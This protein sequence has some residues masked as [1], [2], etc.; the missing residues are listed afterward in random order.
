MVQATSLADTSKSGSSQV[1][2][3]N[4]DVVSVQPANVTLAPLSQQTFAAIVLGASNQSVTWQVQGAGCAVSGG[5][6]TVTAN[7][8]YTAPASPPTPNSVQVVA[9]SQD[10]PA[11]SGAANV[12]ISTEANILSLHP[13]SVY[14]GGANGFTLR[15]DGSGFAASSPGPGS[16]LLI[17]G[18]ART[19]TCISATECTAAVTASDMAAVGSVSVQVRNPSGS[20]SNAVEL[21]VAAPNVSDEVISLTSGAPIATGKD[22]VAVE[23]TTAGISGP[24]NPLDLNVAAIGVFSTADNACA[25]TGNPIVLAR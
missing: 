7:G 10:D 17:G 2:V 20:S 1:T 11:Q 18:T 23:P 9:V 5:C 4:H 21:V 12:T 3:I 25:L 19:T 6:G 14:A 8:I 22:I 16:T 13:A 15:V 24:G